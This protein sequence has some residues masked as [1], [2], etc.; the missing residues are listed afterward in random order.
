[1][2]N[3]LPVGVKAR[4]PITAFPCQGPVPGTLKP[5]TCCSSMVDCKYKDGTIHMPMWERYSDNHMYTCATVP[6]PMDKGR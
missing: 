2:K 5:N 3:L 6:V 4:D 1:M